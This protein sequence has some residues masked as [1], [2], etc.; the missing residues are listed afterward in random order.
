MRFWQLC[1]CISSTHL[2]FASISVT[3]PPKFLLFDQEKDAPFLS[4]VLKQTKT[5]RS[6]FRFRH[7]Y[8]HIRLNL[9]L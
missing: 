3:E 2:A 5:Y 9:N 1:F 8:I 4:P 6:K 7:S